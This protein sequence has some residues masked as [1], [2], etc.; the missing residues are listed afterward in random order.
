MDNAFFVRDDVGCDV[1][2][3]TGAANIFAMPACFDWETRKIVNWLR[4]LTRR[5]VPVPLHLGVIAD[6]LMAAEG[7]TPQRRILG[8]TL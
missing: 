3:E 1:V 7:L 8:I 2:S 6:N 4:A 5:A